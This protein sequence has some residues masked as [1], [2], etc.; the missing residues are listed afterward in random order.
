MTAFALFHRTSGELLRFHPDVNIKDFKDGNFKGETLTIDDGLA[1]V[2]NIRPT[3]FEV[4]HHLDIEEIK[5]YLKE[6]VAFLISKQKEYRYKI[7]PY[8][9]ILTTAAVIDVFPPT[10]GYYIAE[11]K[12]VKPLTYI[13]WS[14]LPS[15]QLPDISDNE[16]VTEE[17]LNKIIPISLNILQSKWTHRASEYFFFDM[18]FKL[19]RISSEDDIIDEVNKILG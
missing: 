18:E 13:T 6:I 11:R 15:N 3:P 19:D 7:N 1:I 17:E 4:S 2:Y 10:N 9:D 8:K 16:Y 12:T 5:Q 14:G